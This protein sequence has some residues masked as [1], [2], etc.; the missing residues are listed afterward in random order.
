MT[1]APARPTNSDPDAS[2]RAEILQ[3]AH[4]LFIR[5][6]FKKTTMDD[7]A[8]QAGIGKA[9]IYYYFRSKKDLLLGY[10]DMC[11]AE[12]NA[13]VQEAVAEPGHFIERLTRLMRTKMLGIYDHVHAGPHGEEI[14]NELFPILVERHIE[15]I[16]RTKSLLTELLQDA[17]EAGTVRIDD[18]ERASHMLHRAFQSFAPPYTPLTGTR[19]EIDRDIE[20]MAR[21]VYQGLR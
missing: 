20:A 12:N 16:C 18:P 2:K 4:S 21:L 14:F 19:E 11:L 13:R 8:A 17:Q 9:T 6:G 1:P 3:A 5:Y 10:A 7:L 15:E